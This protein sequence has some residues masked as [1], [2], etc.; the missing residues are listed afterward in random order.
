MAART[1]AD[2]VRRSGVLSRCDIIVDASFNATRDNSIATA[3]VSAPTLRQETSGSIGDQDKE[4]RK[5]AC[6]CHARPIAFAHIFNGVDNRHT[7]ALHT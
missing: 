2:D 4:T 6:M 7:R 3:Q 5:A 1:N